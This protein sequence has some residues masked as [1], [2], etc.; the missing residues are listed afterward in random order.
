VGVFMCVCVVFVGVVCVGV[1]VGVYV[2]VCMRG[3][4]WVCVCLWCVFMCL[5]VVCVWVCVC[6][7]V[8]MCFVCVCVWVGVCV[9]AC[10]YL[11]YLN[12]I[13]SSGFYRYL[14]E[15]EWEGVER[16]RVA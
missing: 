6:V 7:F 9:C 14:A 12:S 8:W 16:V 11:L 13:Y 5:C 4:V 3:G 10:V 2:S 1:C 15:R